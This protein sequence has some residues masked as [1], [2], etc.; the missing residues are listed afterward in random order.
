MQCSLPGVHATGAPCLALLYEASSRGDLQTVRDLVGRGCDPRK[1][2]DSRGC[3][4]VDVAR[5]HNHEHVLEY[6]IELSKI[7]LT[8]L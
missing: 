2:M 6:Y 3:T 1:A 7:L 8:Q 4:A 5:E